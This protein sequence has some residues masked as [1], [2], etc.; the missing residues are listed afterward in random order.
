MKRPSY[1][2]QSHLAYFFVLLRVISR[3]VFR[4]NYVFLLCFYPNPTHFTVILMICT[5][6]GGDP[7]PYCDIT[8]TIWQLKSTRQKFKMR[9][10]NMWKVP[11]VVCYLYA[12]FSAVVTGIYQLQVLLAMET[13]HL[14]GHAYYQC[15]CCTLGYK[16][17]H[18]SLFLDRRTHVYWP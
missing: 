15:G 1:C 11:K 5:V 12:N 10:S 8:L 6:I 4:G 16:C 9:I 7:P 3:Y 14:N 17:G 2:T 13:Q 18:S